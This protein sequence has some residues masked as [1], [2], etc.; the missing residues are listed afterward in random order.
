MKKLLILF[1]FLFLLVIAFPTFVH[2]QS[3]NQSWKCLD[4]AKCWDINEEP[5]CYFD[6][7]NS[8]MQNKYG[9][10]V[11]IRTDAENKPLPSSK[12][13][14]IECVVIPEWLKIPLE[15]KTKYGF[16][17]DT[18]PTEVCTTGNANFDN[19]LGIFQGTNPHD[20]LVDLFS[21]Y[22]WTDNVNYPP[23]GK[24][25]LGYEFEGYFDY[26]LTT[27]YQETNQGYFM[28]NA[29]GDFNHDFLYLSHTWTW[30]Q[31]VEQYIGRKMKALN[32]IEDVTGTGSSLVEEEKTQQQGTFDFDLPTNASDCEIISW[33]P[34][35]KVFDGQTLEP[36]QNA[37]IELLKKRTDGKFSKVTANDLPSKSITN[38][39]STP[40]EGTFSFVV[41]DGTYRLTASK[42]DYSFPNI[43][44]INPNFKY[45]YSDIYRGEDI[46]QKGKIQH[47]DIPLDPTLLKM[48]SSPAQFIQKFISKRKDGTV[49][50]DGSVTHP[51]AYIKAYC[52]KGNG[53]P[54]T[55]ISSSQAD[56]DGNFKNIV[57]QKKCPV[58]EMFNVLVVEK[59]DLS[60]YPFVAQKQSEIAKTYKVNPMLS[61]L[62]GYAYNE[63]GNKIP[64]AIAGIYL[65]GGLKPY[66][67]TEADENGY[68]KIDSQHLP[69]WQYTIKYTDATG[70]TNQI[71]TADFIVSNKQLI[72]SNKI[73]LYSQKYIQKDGTIKEYPTPKQITPIDQNNQNNIIN[74]PG[75]SQIKAEIFLLIFVIVILIIIAVGI[76]IYVK[77]NPLLTK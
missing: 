30:D 67:Q 40:L 50:V 45:I 12:T 33:D 66:Y 8:E 73:N 53:D 10:A 19:N 31:N 77:K 51:F 43:I 14:I 7:N 18:I 1:V 15:I 56:K 74:K 65:L 29:D 13:Y 54:T 4:V 22:N 48:S 9:H 24:K 72:D 64:K 60:S 20:L 38:P 28:T 5:T 44:K 17:D 16:T 37:Q 69:L 26:D 57:D 42:S 70:Q 11:R 32:L 27:I 3:F 25:H 46:V 35:G 62:E 71:T 21:G 2:G 58:G 41:P 52:G 36:V 61:Y 63:K 23:P 47:R 6:K 34:Y 76:F 75:N 39:Y 55:L 59:A 49:M 68:F